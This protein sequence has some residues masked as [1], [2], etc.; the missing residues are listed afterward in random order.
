MDDGHTPVY[1]D[2]V[3]SDEDLPAA[4]GSED[5]RQVIRIRDMSPDVQI[6]DISQVGRD[7]DSRRTVW[8]VGYPK[9]CPG[10]RIPRSTCVPA[11]ATKGRAKDDTLGI[12][13]SD[14]SPVVETVDLPE[15]GW[16][17]TIQLSSPPR[18][19]QLSPESPRMIAFEDLGDSSVPLSP[20]RVQAGRSQE[21]PD[22]GS[23]FNVSP[24]SPGF[25]MC[26][27]GAAGQQPEA[28]LPS[29]L[30]SFSDPFLGDPIAFAQCALITGSDTPLTLPVYT[31][32]SGLAGSVFCSDSIGVGGVPSA[33]GVVLR[34][35]S[36][37]GHC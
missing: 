6:V 33:G 28:G 21:V 27:S 2:Q 15:V 22:D 5:R 3:L 23:L 37:C 19:G 20:N 30:D 10:K 32:P 29:A 35:G 36:D 9:D 34:Y 4:A 18:S 13:A 1:S 8:G 14:P 17:E 16:V 12:A 7:W 25:S 26:P 24:V 31:M 11:T